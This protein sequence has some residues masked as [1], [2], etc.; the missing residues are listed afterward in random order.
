MSRRQGGLGGLARRAVCG[1][2]GLLPSPAAD[3]CAWHALA[4]REVF[5]LL[6]ATGYKCTSRGL[7]E[8]LTELPTSE[9]E[10]LKYLEKYT[11]CSEEVKKTNKYCQV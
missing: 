1:T 5:A 7:K 3:A 2:Q 6:A 8:M 11:S 4:R 10:F 9:Q